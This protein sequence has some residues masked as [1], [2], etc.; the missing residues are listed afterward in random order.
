MV[1]FLAAESWVAP[2]P[3]P[4]LPFAGFLSPFSP[5]DVKEKALAEAELLP[6]SLDFLLSVAGAG[7]LNAKEVPPG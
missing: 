4:K 6:F 5:V 3:G 1:S 2:V 7:A